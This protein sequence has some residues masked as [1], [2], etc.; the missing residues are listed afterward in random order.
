M[1]MRIVPD[2]LAEILA[3]RAKAI[4]GGNSYDIKETLKAHKYRLDAACK[5][6]HKTV[7]GGIKG[8]NATSEMEFL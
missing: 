5:I 4:A 7:T 6:W 2:S 3:P 1:L 8:P